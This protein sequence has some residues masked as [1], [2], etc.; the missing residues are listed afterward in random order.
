[1]RRGYEAAMKAIF[2][3]GAASYTFTQM[4]SSQ[5]DAGQTR[6]TYYEMWPVMASANPP[7]APFA[8]GGEKQEG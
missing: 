2:E 5:R 6:A 7:D 1:M 8:G 4:R 3:D